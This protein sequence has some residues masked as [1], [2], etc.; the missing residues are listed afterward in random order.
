MEFDLDR[1]R[2]NVRTASTEDLLDRATVYRAGLEPEALP[3]ILEELRS[4]GVSP[5]AVVAHEEGRN[6]V[7][8]DESGTAR[9][10]QRRFCRKPAVTV[11]WG[12]FRL[13]DKLPVFPRRYYLC[14]DHCTS[15]DYDERAL[16]ERGR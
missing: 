14:E 1:V 13:F 6:G 8:Y 16:R 10:C 9:Q 4:R 11:E 12:W 15:R 3:V 7:V 2:A 5:G